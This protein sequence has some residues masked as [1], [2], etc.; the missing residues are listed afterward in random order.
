MKSEEDRR[1]LL[2]LMT[3]V[4]ACFIT[5]LLTLRHHDNAAPH[6]SASIDPRIHWPPLPPLPYWPKWQPP[7]DDSASMSPYSSVAAANA[8]QTHSLADS[9]IRRSPDSL[10]VKSFPTPSF[11]SL[12]IG[13]VN[14]NQLL[15]TYPP[16]SESKEARAEAITEFQHVIAGRAE[17]HD[18]IVVFDISGKSLNGVSPLLAAVQSFDLTEEV[19]DQLIAEHSVQLLTD[20][21]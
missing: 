2:V 7:G 18:C 1:K 10:S 11:Q 19:L 8:S 12:T 15:A 14:V 17:A 5:V 4:V 3:L 6:S 13:F 20:T 16:K 9:I 21:H